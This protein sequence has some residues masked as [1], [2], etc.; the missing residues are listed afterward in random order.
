[1]EEKEIQEKEHY[2]QKEKLII[3]LEKQQ[4]ERYELIFKRKCL[5]C[6]QMLEGNRN[7]L[8]AHFYSLHGFNVGK[9]DNL[10]NVDELLD[11]LESKM[12]KNIC[13][14]CEKTFRDYETL[15]EHMRK[16]KHFK[17][18]K[19]NR[20]YDKFYIIN[21]LEQGKGWKEIESEDS[22]S[23][24]ETVSEVDQGEQDN[25][26][27]WE[28]A[29]DKDSQSKCL[30]CNELLINANESFNHIKLIHHFDFSEIA[31]SL[32]LDFY[33]SI[34]LINFIRKSVKKNQCIFCTEQFDSSEKLI[35]HM[36][37][38]QHFQLDTSNLVWSSEEYLIPTIENDPLLWSFEGSFESDDEEEKN[39]K[40]IQIADLLPDGL[41][42]EE[43]ERK[44]REFFG[45]D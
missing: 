10:V 12:E 30:F 18:H 1:M 31:Y 6:K 36:E 4:K 37:L 45:Q 40:E 32:K 11:L 3:L 38:K 16:K 15:R 8:F 22:L 2:E 25:W 42:W 13:I 33:G 5:F 29:E 19:D 39:Q 24:S 20:E 23:E 17:L 27:E 14:Y 44:K 35:S 7:V 26:D 34:K 9:T 28:E 21:F 41:T 43:I